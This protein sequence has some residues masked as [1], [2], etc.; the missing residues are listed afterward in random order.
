MDCSSSEDSVIVSYI[1]PRT[2]AIVDV[3]W[4]A[5]I[6]VQII[7]VSLECHPPDSAAGGTDQVSVCMHAYSE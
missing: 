4:D 2:E 7:E 1:D 6:I 5:G 3:S